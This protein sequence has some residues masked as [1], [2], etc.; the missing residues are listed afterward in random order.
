[1]LS[2]NL[3]LRMAYNTALS[4]IQYNGSPVPV[5]WQQLP[6]TVQAGL[7]IIFGQIRNND[8]SNKTSAVTQTS[9]TVSVFTNSLKY[10]DGVAVEAVANE[11]MNRI[12]PTTTFKLPLNSQFFNIVTTTLQ[13]DNTQDFS[14]VN[15]NVYIDRILTF[16]HLIAQNVS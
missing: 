2:S 4:T 5:Y 14:Q 12:L 13:S 8:N 6:T 15:Q 10:N 1:M 16:S 7:Y 3:E 11:V 9:V